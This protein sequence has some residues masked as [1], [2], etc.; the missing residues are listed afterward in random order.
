MADWSGGAADTAAAALRARRLP[1]PVTPDTACE[2]DCADTACGV[3]CADTACGTECTR[4]AGLT[5]LT[6]R[7]G[8]NVHGVRG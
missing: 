7:A 8:L 1:R 2:A 5:M 6:R 3:D 4:R